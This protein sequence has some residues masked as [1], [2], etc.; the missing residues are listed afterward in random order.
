MKIMRYRCPYCGCYT[1]KMELL[2]TKYEPNEKEKREHP[3]VAGEWLQC[4][5]NRILK[6]CEMEKVEYNDNLC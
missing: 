3:N 6:W 5:C 4:K 2:E 1:N